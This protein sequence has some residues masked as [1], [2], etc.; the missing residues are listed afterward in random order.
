MPKYSMAA[1]YPGDEYVDWVGV[2]LYTEPYGNGEKSDPILGTSPI[3]R[4]DELYR[5][6]ADRK[7]IMLS[8]TAV[9]HKTHKNEESFTEWTKMNLDRL[10]S[11]MPKRYPRLK[12]ITYFNS[13]LKSR[14]SQNDYLLR[15]NP[16]VMDLYKKLIADP[17]FLTKVEQGAEPAAPVGY[18]K[19]ETSASFSKEAR[20]V[21]FAKIPDIYIG[22][23]DYTLNGRL[24]ASQTSPPYGISLSA[25]EVPEGS[26]LQVQ[27]F[28]QA[29]K[30]AAVKSITLSSRVS[31][32]LDGKDCRFEQPPVI[33]NGST[34][35][36]MRAVF[37]AMGATVQWDQASLTASGRKGTTTISLPIGQ[38]NA[39][40]NGE[41]VPLEV[42]AQLINNFTMAPVRFIGEAFGGKVEWDNRTRTVRISTR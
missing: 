18:V 41:V 9:A 36:P 11:I 16:A 2:S 34:L 15:D 30:Q 38:L 21:P 5:L 33:R 19:A 39:R 31:I 40:R 25:G 20:I 24:V 23:I 6:Y 27:V 35:A 42:P 14:D 10:Y 8:E 13:D 22:R 1:Y 28:N 26:V 3:E 29:G 17:S 7:P 32:Q 12:A 37:E 4:L